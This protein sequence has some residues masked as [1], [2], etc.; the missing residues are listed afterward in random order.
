MNITKIYISV[1]HCI[2]KIT[3]TLT[4]TVFFSFFLNGVIVLYSGWLNQFVFLCLQWELVELWFI[5]IGYDPRGNHTYARM[6]THPFTLMHTVSGR[7][8][9]APGM[10]DWVVAYSQ[11]SVII[12]SNIAR[13]TGQMGQSD[14]LKYSC[15][16]PLTMLTSALTVTLHL[17][18]R[19]W[20]WYFFLWGSRFPPDLDQIVVKGN[21]HKVDV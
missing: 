21:C 20:I 13:R 18:E 6:E 15:V 10:V 7:S 8:T 16:V 2:I 19:C 11:M 3:P 17:A 4:C 1:Q 5:T 9:P 12:C 14:S